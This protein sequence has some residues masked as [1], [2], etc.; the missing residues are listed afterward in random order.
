MNF[1]ILISI[2]GGADS[3]RLS[4]SLDWKNSMSFT[5]SDCLVSRFLAR[6]LGLFLLFTET[7]AMASPKSIKFLSN[8][9]EKNT[10]SIP[11]ISSRLT[12]PLM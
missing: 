9:L 10:V 5:K 4:N 7:S 11:S 6:V 12:E 1:S 3:P 8:T 2:L